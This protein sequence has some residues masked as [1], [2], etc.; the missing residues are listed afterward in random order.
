MFR[1]SRVKGAIAKYL[2]DNGLHA[3]TLTVFEQGPLDTF[4][5]HIEN[6]GLNGW[7]GAVF[8]ITGGITIMAKGSQLSFLKSNYPV[9]YNDLVVLWQYCGAL[10]ASNPQELANSIYVDDIGNPFEYADQHS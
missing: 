1:K 3:D 8:V 7:Q 6:R 5:P 10:Y 4:L 9:I 2:L